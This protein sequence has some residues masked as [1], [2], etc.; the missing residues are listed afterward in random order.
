MKTYEQFCQLDEG[1][2]E[3]ARRRAQ[4]AKGMLPKDGV[5]NKK[6]SAM[7][8]VPGKGRTDKEG[9]LRRP[10]ES[11]RP[12]V[13]INRI[14]QPKRIN[15]SQLGIQKYKELKNKQSQPGLRG[16]KQKPMSL[17]NLQRHASRPGRTAN[18]L[19]KA[20]VRDFKRDPL[21]YAGKAANATGKAAKAVARTAFN[22]A[23]P[24]DVKSSSGSSLAGKGSSVV[25]K[26]S[27]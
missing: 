10:S 7:V 22:A 14:T 15:R 20:A 26:Y 16:G 8:H 4:M 3:E 5:N 19:R 18:T 1:A 27:K 12:P 9:I 21:K 24:K 13:G 6:S 23:K 2:A 17:K 11:R 25:S